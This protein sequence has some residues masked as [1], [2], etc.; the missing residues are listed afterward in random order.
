MGVPNW[1]SWDM[2]EHKQD[3]ST[4]EWSGSSPS[5]AEC[6]AYVCTKQEWL[7]RDGEGTDENDR[8]MWRGLISACVMVFGFISSASFLSSSFG[9]VIIAIGILSLIHSMSS[10]SQAKKR[11]MQMREEE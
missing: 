9:M 7:E 8:Y 2:V 4:S 11:Y 6:G 10:Y 1:K 3:G 5:C